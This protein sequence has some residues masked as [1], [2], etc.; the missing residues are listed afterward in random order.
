MRCLISLQTDQLISLFLSGSC[1]QTNLSNQP[2]ADIFSVC[3]KRNTVRLENNS[4]TLTNTKSLIRWAEVVAQLVERSLRTPK[5]CGLNPNI[6]QVLFTKFNQIEKIKIKKKR[7]GMA[8]LFKKES[9]QI[10][11]ALR[12]IFIIFYALSAA[13]GI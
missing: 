4:S 13:G 5:I 12:F 10:T 2:S 6:G 11:K 3:F 9:H 8:H 7:L 1:C